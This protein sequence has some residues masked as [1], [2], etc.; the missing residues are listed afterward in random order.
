MR[1]FHFSCLPRFSRRDRKIVG[2]YFHSFECGDLVT[3]AR[4][5]EGGCPT[6]DKNI[7]PIKHFQLDSII[8]FFMEWPATNGEQ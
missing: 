1:S 3:F 8:M 4:M 2:F 7:T 5:K 6:Q